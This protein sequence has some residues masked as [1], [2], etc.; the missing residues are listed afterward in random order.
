MIKIPTVD[1]II[2]FIFPNSYKVM[3]VLLV[4]FFP[5]KIGWIFRP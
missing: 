4:N 2:T 1:F 5:K 3:I